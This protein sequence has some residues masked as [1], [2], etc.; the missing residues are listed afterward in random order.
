MLT[1]SQ[2]PLLDAVDEGRLGQPGGL[3]HGRRD[4]DDVVELGRISP[5]AWMP[6][7]QCTMVPLRVPPQCEATCLVH[8][9]GVSIAWAQPTA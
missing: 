5:L 4:V 7:G 3:E 1:P 2:R 8:W 6:V 9:Y